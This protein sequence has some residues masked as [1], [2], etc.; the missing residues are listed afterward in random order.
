MS[1]N[2]DKDTF[3]RRKDYL[4]ILI[5]ILIAFAIFY[6]LFYS[7]YLYTDEAVQLWLYKKGTGFQMFL[8]QGRY[9]TDKLFQWLFSKAH[10]IHDVTYIRLFSFFGWIICIPV[11]YFIVRR[12]VITEKLPGVLA[13]F[14][15]LYLVCTPPFSMS[16]SWASCLELFIA[17]TTGLVSGYALY[18]SVIYKEGR[19]KLPLM[20]I[21]VLFGVVS[22]FTYQNGFGC[23]LLPFLLHLMS[24]PKNFRIVFV[25]IIG[26]FIIYVIYYLLFK[27][28]LEVNKITASG[29]TKI[30]IDLF[31]KIRFFFGRALAMSFHFTY[32]FNEKNI[33]GFFVYAIIFLT[34]LITDFYHYR[35]LPV[36]RRLMILALTLFLL[37]LIYLPSLII[38]ENYS[39]NRTLFALNMAV[40]FLVANTFLTVVKKHETR[41]TIVSMLSF[42]FVLNARNNFSQ[43][44]LRPVKT[45]YR[46]VRSFIERNYD[47]SIDTI[48]FIR[49]KEDFFVRKFGVTR[50]WDEFGVPSTFFD[51]VPGFFT[52]QVV[53]EKT[54]NRSMAE[55]LVIKHWLDKEE[56]IK[57][58][59]RLSQNILLVDTEEIMSRQ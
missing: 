5:L 4:N 2:H 56:F 24:R 16:V 43:Q 47:A 15:V 52:K 31:P 34:W 35:I 48:Y 6:P 49:P 59:P 55:R 46:Q 54:R 19:M 1:L 12:I 44:F 40:F 30:S 9:I 25:G 8:P 7:E 57:S 42:L 45:E 20:A 13:F 23:F 53:F 37:V 58:A 50:S 41:I 18:S 51:W 39:S 27:Y 10:T 28:N 17:N 29:R 22:L 11:W 14:S 26:C 38:K 33:T 36:T 21:A 32:L 3:F